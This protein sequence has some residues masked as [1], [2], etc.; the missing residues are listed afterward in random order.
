MYYLQQPL[1]NLYKDM[2]NNTVDKSKWNAKKYS[3]NPQREKKG[4][5][6]KQQREI[7]QKTK[8]T[9]FNLSIVILKVN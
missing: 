7:K 2:L 4:K 3:G 5:M 1:K 6:E 9:D 8:M